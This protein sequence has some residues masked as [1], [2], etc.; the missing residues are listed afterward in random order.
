MTRILSKF[1]QFWT[2][3]YSNI[4]GQDKA[5][6]GEIFN[7]SD[8]SSICTYPGSNPRKYDLFF[9]SPLEKVEDY[10][11]RRSLEIGW[12]GGGVNTRHLDCKKTVKISCFCLVCTSSNVMIKCE[13]R[14]SCIG[15][16]RL[17]LAR[18]ISKTTFFDVDFVVMMTSGFAESLRFSMEPDFT[19]QILFAGWPKTCQS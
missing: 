13:A 9:K 19:Q 6:P 17:S 14:Y 2:V 8:V 5:V 15:G 18:V 12:G 1:K 10:F 7:K 4:L 16:E 3:F 11:L